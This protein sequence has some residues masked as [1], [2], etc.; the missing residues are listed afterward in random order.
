MTSPSTKGV[1]NIDPPRRRRWLPWLIAAVLFCGPL[2]RVA[3]LYWQHDGWHEI[4]LGLETTVVTEPR[5]PDGFVDFAGAINA[6]AG[7]G[8]TPE[9]NA[10]V[11][12]VQAYGPSEIAPAER[13]RYFELL[14]MAPLPESGQY[15]IDDRE[16]LLKQ[17]EPEDG[18]PARLEQF[19]NDTGAATT[20]P[21]SDT[22]FPALAEFLK[23]NDAPL[24]RVIEATRRERYFSPLATP[25]AQLLSLHYPIEIQNRLAARLLIMRAMHRLDSGDVAGSWDD[26]LAC[27]RLARLTGKSLHSMSLLVSYALN[28]MAAVGANA[29]IRDP[30]LSAEQARSCLADLDTLPPLREAYEVIDFEERLNVIDSYCRLLRGMAPYHVA[31]RQT[32]QLSVKDRT[33]DWNLV[34]RQA[35]THLDEMVRIMQIDDPNERDAEFKR[36]ENL[37]FPS[38]GN[39]KMFV[40]AFLGASEEMSLEFEKAITMLMWP[41]M[42]R[43][44]E[45][46]MTTA[47]QAQL[48]RLGFAL[49]VHR[50]E[51]GAFPDSLAELTPG[52][53]NELP[54]DPCSGQAFVYR[55]TDDGYVLYSLGYNR[56]DDNGAGYEDDPQGDDQALR[57]RAN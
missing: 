45:A 53:L 38:A 56:T 43:L 24:Q 55:R 11:L 4:E 9:N 26:I 37:N 29:I 41:A 22:E 36:V 3:Y 33:I 49:A 1:G 48:T 2:L 30:R 47:A 18:L 28:R 12:L 34:L 20:R 6:R 13:T 5:T 25:D 42:F 21:W 46:Q 39:W 15:L 54:L 19:G 27:H 57:V 52:L 10:V 23:A 32:P 31:N 50:H 14:G 17:G 8:V 16:F 7:A 44:R 51:H 40:K 35:N